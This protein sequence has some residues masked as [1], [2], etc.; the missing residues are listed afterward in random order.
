MKNTRVFPFIALGV[1]FAG[2]LS[3]SLTTANLDP[4]KA[5]SSEEVDL[6]TG[7]QPAVVKVQ[8]TAGGDVDVSYLKGD[9]AGWASQS[10]NVRLAWGGSDTILHILLL[11]E[12]PGKS[13]LVIRD[14]TDAWICVGGSSGQPPSVDLE[15]PKAG[16]IS[17][18]AATSSKSSTSEG[19]VYITEKS[20]SLDDPLDLDSLL[21]G[22]GL[23]ELEDLDNLQDDLLGD[24]GF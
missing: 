5:P 15:S 17:I 11:S 24:L 6:T 9:C 10:P 3:C 22:S 16:K 12:D 4:G 18:W 19:T 21:E 2:I 20:A 13:S 7:F 23:E 1:L 14:S 8:T